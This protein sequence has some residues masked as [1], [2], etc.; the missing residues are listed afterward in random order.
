[1]VA[2]VVTSSTATAQDPLLA[3]G[4]FIIAIDSDPPAPDSSS[5]EGE[6]AANAIDSDP[7]TNI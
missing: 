4:D 7:F 3:P 2:A 5:P 1:M 6:G